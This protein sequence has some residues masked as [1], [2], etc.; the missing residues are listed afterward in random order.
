MSV[1][2]TSFRPVLL[3]AVFLAAV[4]AASPGARAANADNPQGNVDRSND[5][6]NSTGNSQVDRLNAGQLDQNQGKQGPAGGAQ[7]PR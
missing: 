3:G 2:V 4:G 5:A 1:R 7:P 6:G